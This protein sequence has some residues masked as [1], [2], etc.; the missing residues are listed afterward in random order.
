MTHSTFRR[1]RRIAI[2]AP[3]PK[4]KKED[5]PLTDG[6]EGMIAFC[7]NYIRVPIYP[8]GSTVPEWTLMGE[9]PAESI[10]DDGRSYK[11]LWEEQQEILREGLSM[12]NGRFN[13]R[14]LV[15]CWM[16]GEGKCQKKGSE[17][18]MFDGSVKKVEDVKVGD[19]LMG[20]DNT[21]RK[22]LSLASGKEEMFEV[23]PM[24]GES[25]TVTGDHILSLKRRRYFRNRRGKPY[26]D[27]RVGEIVD[28]SLK[29]YQK[30][31]NS[32]KAHHLLYRVPV[33]FPEQDV[34]I[35][36]YFLGIWL[37]DGHSTV[38]SI[39]SMDKEVV[40]YLRSYA[41]QLGLRVSVRG[42]K[43]NKAKTYSIVGEKLGIEGT[44]G[45]LNLLREYNLVNNKH[46]P[47][48]FKANSREVRLKVLAGIVDSD[49]YIN[50]KSVQ[51]TLK[52]K[53]LSNDILFLARSLGFH[54]ELKKCTK[55]INGTDFVGEYYRIGITGD[56]SIIPT[57]IPRKKC[58]P[59]SDWKDILT[60][61]IRE[62]K[63]TGKQEYYGFNLDGNGRYVTADFT[64]THNSLLVCLILLWKFFVFSEQKI[65]LGA[66]SK[67]QVKFVHFDII[68]DII[69]NSPILLKWV[70]GKRNIQEKEIRLKDEFGNIRSLIRSISSFSGI[71]SNITGYS[72]S[73]IF[74]MKNPKFFVQLDGSIRNVPNAFGIIDS[75]VSEKTH[76]LYKLYSQALGRKTKGVFFSYRFSRNGDPQDYW[77][78]N[79]TQEQL[80]DYKA[81][82]PFGEYERYFLNLW[83]AG[84]DAIFSPEMIEEM[85]YF[86]SN[87]TLL[88]HA[89]TY[90]LLEKKH[91]MI[92]MMKDSK[93]KGLGSIV[94]NYAEAITKIDIQFN[95]VTD[96]YSLT[97][98][99]NSPTMASIDN[100]MDLTEIFDTNWA[101]LAGIDF[102][103]P[104][105]IRSMARSIFVVIA[106]GLPRSRTDYLAGLGTAPAYLYCV[107]HVIDISDHSINAVKEELEKVNDEYEGIDTFC[108]ER[109]GAWDVGNWCEDRNILFEPVYPTYDRQREAFKEVLIAARDGRFKIPPTRIRGSKKDDLT[110]EEFE[111]FN[112]D[113]EK[114]WFGSVEKAEKYGIQDDFI[115]ATGWGL[116]GGRNLGVDDFRIR[117]SKKG[118]GSFFPNHENLGVYG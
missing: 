107:L 73:E 64:V 37:G 56:C 33:E 117:R 87:K 32:F 85:G 68:R 82:F 43:N 40:S 29:D 91:E 109:Y 11:K 104:Y 53:T 79:M 46:I 96:V 89:E 58:S 6:A 47:Q 39:T 61:G 54:A 108:S 101:I 88:N 52:D 55:G 30:Q 93:G 35:D 67:D 110:R 70:G 116:Y 19:L 16:R 34:G 78:P 26:N 113:Q 5:V 100:L 69:L 76:V 72:F 80:N 57:L 99:Y 94:E 98:A 4:F 65:M 18:L 95:P 97:D 36:P 74:D 115:F 114:R 28:I 21:P 27:T 66:N 105:A 92:A 106:K 42:K 102:A 45:L 48:A 14:L 49:G 25:M 51:I 41:K 44:N 31:N 13:Y 103:D 90:K 62:I 22:V 60:T 83:S 23:I 77:N 20:D 112:H 50:R 75:T 59:R 8:K 63:S 1:K 9:L 71:V 84:K 15:F 7:N 17:I 81:K 3:K 111:T 86:G 10:Y 118:F 2:P 12:K 38:P 24:R